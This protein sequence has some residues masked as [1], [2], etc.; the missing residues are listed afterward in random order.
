MESVSKQD[1][2]LGLSDQS[3]ESVREWWE[4]H[5]AGC[6][7]WWL[8]GTP[9]MQVWTDLA[10]LDQLRPGRNVLNIGVG[11]GHEANDLHKRG[12][13][14][15]CLDIA[16]AALDRVSSIAKTWRADRLADLPADTIDLAA[17]HL[18]AQHMADADLAAQLTAVLRSLK[19]TGL[20]ALQF[21]YQTNNPE[22]RHEPRTLSEK[23]GGILY[24]PRLMRLMIERA[25]GKV[26]LDQPI[27]SYEGNVTHHLVH[28][29][30]R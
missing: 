8:S 6:D 29:A 25:G 26:T 14:V 10:I 2:E 4:R 13:T 3:R 20:F 18:V 11:L 15:H 24:S 1:Q 16:Q 7:P 30:R 12:C 9:P 17:S 23:A 21:A 27:R 19:P 28:A 22:F 5:H